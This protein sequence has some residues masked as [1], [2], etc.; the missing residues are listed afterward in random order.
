MAIVTHI[1]S[2]F[3]VK[4]YMVTFSVF[5]FLQSKWYFVEWELRVVSLAIFYLIDIHWG[6]CIFFTVSFILSFIQVL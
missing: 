4:Q 2:S 3:S 6:L 1:C 5:L